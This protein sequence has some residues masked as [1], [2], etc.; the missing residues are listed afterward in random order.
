M[1]TRSSRNKRVPGRSVLVLAAIAATALAAGAKDKKEQAPYAL[2]FGT[3]FQESG[4]SLPGA[5]IEIVPATELQGARKFK[6]LEAVSDSRGEFAFRVPV[7][8]MTYKLTARAAGYI[9]QEK[10]TQAAGEVRVD[11]F[12][13]LE[14]ASKKTSEEK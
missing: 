9:P 11:V 14:T 1:K 2:I 12:F 13:R 7:E 8:E 4:L 6:R 3:V 5:R 10:I